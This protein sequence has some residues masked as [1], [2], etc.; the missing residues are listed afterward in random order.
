[1]Q[2]IFYMGI[3]PPRREAD[4]LWLWGG[5]S[6]Y[7]EHILSGIFPPRREGT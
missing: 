5:Y 2:S 4:V 3:F 1:M 7:A 6:K